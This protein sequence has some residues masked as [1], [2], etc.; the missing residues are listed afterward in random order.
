VE[1]AEEGFRLYG[2]V[3]TLMTSSCMLAQ[4]F[5]FRLNSEIF[6]VVFLWSFTPCNSNTMCNNFTLTS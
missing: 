5:R 2:V 3:I 4:S 1:C 6:F